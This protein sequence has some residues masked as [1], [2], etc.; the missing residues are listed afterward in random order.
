MKNILGPGIL[1]K[2]KQ[3]KEKLLVASL[4]AGFYSLAQPPIQLYGYS[5]LS[6]P[7][8]VTDKK[9]AN[10]TGKSWDAALDYFFYLSHDRSLQIRPAE[11]WIKGKRFAVTESKAVPSPVYSPGNQLLIAKSSS[12]V[13]ELKHDSPLPALPSPPVWLKK[14]ISQNELVLAYKWKGKKY[15]KALK[16]I[17]ELDTVYNQ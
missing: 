17:R 3:M 15:Y 6:T 1:S 11:I 10:K 13:V 4:L 2:T 12:K 7:G 9:A 8:M 5:Q 14:M 16:T